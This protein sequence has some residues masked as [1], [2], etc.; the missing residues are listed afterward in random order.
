MGN[1]QTELDRYGCEFGRK[2]ALTLEPIKEDVSEVKADVKGLIISVA[3]I[4]QNVQI[5]RGNGNK[6]GGSREFWTS[7]VAL[8]IA[9][10]TFATTIAKVW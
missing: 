5:A 8:A 4:E 6:R 1:G 7:I 10:V 2:L 9:L 3:R